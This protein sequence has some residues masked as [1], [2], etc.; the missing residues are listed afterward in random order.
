MGL[1]RSNTSPMCTWD[2]QP[3]S[4]VLIEGG[5]AILKCGILGTGLFGDLLDESQDGLFGDAIGPRWQRVLGVNEGLAGQWSDQYREDRVQW[6]HGESRL[7]ESGTKSCLRS[8]CNVRQ[9]SG[10]AA[11]TF[12]IQSLHWDLAIWLAV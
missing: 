2:T 6:I 1:A 5:D 4:C 10:N 12:R 7:L 9:G 8:A 11:S 3:K